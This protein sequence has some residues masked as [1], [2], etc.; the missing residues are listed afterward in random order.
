MKTSDLQGALL[1]AQMKKLPGFIEAR[2]ANWRFYREA[3]AK[4]DEWLLLPEPT[5]GSDPSWF[6]FLLTVREGAPFTR[7][8]LVAWLES[9]KIAT[10]MLFAGNMTRQPAFK[11]AP[12]RIVGEL[13]NTDRVMRDTFWIGVWPGTTAEMREWVVASFAQFI[14]AKGLGVR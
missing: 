10:R 1:M 8:E 9:R 12:H 7:N 13:K 11:D 6:G 3:L 5:P 14:A 2:K 4:W